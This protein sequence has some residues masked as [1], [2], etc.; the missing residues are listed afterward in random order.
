MSV[1]YVFRYIL[2]GNVNVGKSCV[3][4]RFVDNEF[5]LVEKT[6]GV[7]FGSRIMTVGDHNIK[8]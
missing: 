1:S 7:E 2:V 5:G 6:V 4:K 3:L 8:L